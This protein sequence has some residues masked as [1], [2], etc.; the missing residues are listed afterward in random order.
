MKFCVPLCPLWLGFW[1][2]PE[3]RSPDTHASRSFIDRDFEIMRH[4][5]GQYIEANPRKLSR[6]DLVPQRAQ[7]AEELPRSFGIL[8]ERRYRHE[9]ADF[10]CFQSRGRYQQLFEFA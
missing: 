3:N 1:P 5:H 7:F 8:S 10:Q 4:A 2:L 9:S 6:T